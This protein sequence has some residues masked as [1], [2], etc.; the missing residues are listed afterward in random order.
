MKPDYFQ[1]LEAAF[2]CV[3]APVPPMTP[4]ERATFNSQRAAEMARAEAR[5]VPTPQLDLGE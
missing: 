3:F 5:R 1:R 4:D 2:A